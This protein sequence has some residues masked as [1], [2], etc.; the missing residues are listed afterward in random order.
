MVCLSGE[1]LGSSIYVLR[2]SERAGF[3]GLSVIPVAVSSGWHGVEL[4]QSL[5]NVCVYTYVH[6]H[7]C[8]C[9]YTHGYTKMINVYVCLNTVTYNNCV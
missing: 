8:M 5:P 6:M 4:I 7:L 1:L 9:R 3:A 2:V